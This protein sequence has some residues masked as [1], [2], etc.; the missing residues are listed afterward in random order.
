M[1]GRLEQFME[2]DAR[3]L[4]T[5]IINLRAQLVSECGGPGT[6]QKLSIFRAI[7]DA[8]LKQMMIMFL[9]RSLC[10]F[11]FIYFRRRQAQRLLPPESE[12]A[13]TRLPVVVVV[14]AAADI[15][16]HHKSFDFGRVKVDFLS[17]LANESRISQQRILREISIIDARRQ[18]AA[19]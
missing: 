1:R 11:I 9:L 14:V 4:L 6:P 8:S 19:G 16:R 18:C 15:V 17:T 10:G 13:H 7:N 12:Q 5:R 2:C 3:L